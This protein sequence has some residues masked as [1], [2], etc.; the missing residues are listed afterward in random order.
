MS[1]NPPFQK[2]VRIIRSALKGDKNGKRIYA[3]AT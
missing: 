1:E 3:N 2:G